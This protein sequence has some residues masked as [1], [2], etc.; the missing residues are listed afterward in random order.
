MPF[1]DIITGISDPRLAELLAEC[2]CRH[3]SGS[4]SGSGGGG[5]PVNC[6][7]C[8]ELVFPDMLICTVNATCIGTQTFSLTKL[9]EE[10]DGNCHEPTYTGSLSGPI[11]D[12][13]ASCISCVNGI[14]ISV[15]S[16]VD[17]FVGVTLK[18][19]K[20]TSEDVHGHSGYIWGL[21][22]GYSSYTA[23]VYK[24]VANGSCG[25]GQSIGWAIAPDSCAPLMFGLSV[26]VVCVNNATCYTSCAGGLPAN[27]N[28]AATTCT[29]C[30][31]STLTVDISE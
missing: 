18:C 7:L 5:G 6:C 9:S 26:P 1:S 25:T 22:A 14:G 30:V 4:G 24:N 15:T 10:I 16:G 27:D 12:L 17:W 19:W 11:D 23:G 21:L 3:G 29:N 13:T 20:C 31:G 2:C 28:M 8:P